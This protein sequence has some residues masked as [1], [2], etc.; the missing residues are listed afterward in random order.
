MSWMALITVM[1]L[2]MNSLRAMAAWSSARAAD[3]LMEK[4][5]LL[6]ARG[7][8]GVASVAEGLMRWGRGRYWAV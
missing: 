4:G 5:L 2:M 8:V 1:W 3:S 7:V 6:G